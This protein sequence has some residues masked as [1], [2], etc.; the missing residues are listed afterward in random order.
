MG[1]I[2]LPLYQ[3]LLIFTCLISGALHARELQGVKFP[4]NLTCEGKEIPLQG[5]GLRTATVFGIKVYVLGFYAP[6]PIASAD[7]ANLLKRPMC[8]NITYLRNFD[9]DDVDKAW[10]F[11]FKE[12]SAFPYPEM[13]DHVA[14]LQKYFGEIKGERSHSF[15]LADGVTTVF[16]NGVKKGEIKGVEFQKNFLSLWFGSKPPTKDLQEAIMKKSKKD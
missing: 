9:N 13:K 14:E 11:Q 3:T 5:A 10:E 15:S 6:E 4:E 8:F 16:E 1:R 12:S 7:D 2:T